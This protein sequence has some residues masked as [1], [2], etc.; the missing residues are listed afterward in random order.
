M[1]GLSPWKAP[2]A[3]RISQGEKSCMEVRRQSR[4][5]QWTGGEE[6]VCGLDRA[7]DASR[8][9]ASGKAK[10][11]AGL[12]RDRLTRGE[13]LFPRVGL[14]PLEPR[15]QRLCRIGRAAIDALELVPAQR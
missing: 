14:E 2:S 12:C 13:E 8:H 5:S 3:I 6:A 11:F 10:R 1:A 9:E 7:Q 15:R 4:E